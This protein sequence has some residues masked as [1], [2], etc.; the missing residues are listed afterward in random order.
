MV[1]AKLA[2]DYRVSVSFRGFALLALC[3]TLSATAVTACGSRQ[4]P[5]DPVIQ[6]GE[7]LRGNWL[8]TEFKPAETL[9]A[10]IQGLLAAQFNALVLT[11]DGGQMTAR[12]PGVD[13]A[14]NYRVTQALGAEFSLEI[15]DP[16]GVTYRVSAAFEQDLLRFRSHDSPFRGEGTLRR[17][18]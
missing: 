15:I 5:P 12:G 1:G 8:L 6:T 18:Q 16:T 10:P 7:R 2:G 11:F 17:T 9:E 3:G 14:R 13:V 4:T